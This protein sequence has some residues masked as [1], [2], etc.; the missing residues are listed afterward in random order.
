[1]LFQRGPARRVGEKAWVRGEPGPIDFGAAQ[2]RPKGER[3]ADT[4]ETKEADALEEKFHD[5]H[6]LQKLNEFVR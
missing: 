2:G 4:G 1:M 3:A 6:T 5:G